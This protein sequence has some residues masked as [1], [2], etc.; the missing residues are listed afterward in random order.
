MAEKAM[1][2]IGGNLRRFVANRQD[3]E[4][5]C[6][7]MAGCNFAGIAFAWARLGNVHA[8]SHPVSAYFHV[9]HGVA[10]SILLPTVIEYNTLADNGRYEVIYNYIRKN[11]EVL[12]GFKPEMLVE[13]LKKLNADLGIPKSLSEVGVKEE[14]IEKMANDAMMSGNIP[15]N[16]RQTNVKDIIELYK[17]AL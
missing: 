3:E 11:N 10:N 15:A 8:M 17:K 1:E 6:A 4:A 7:M 16:P 12:N 14:M 9:P 2:L 13:E 5:A